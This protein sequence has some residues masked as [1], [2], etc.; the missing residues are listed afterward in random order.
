YPNP[1]ES[2]YD[3][4][5]TGHAGSSVSTALGLKSGDD[6]MGNLD[7]H[8][9]AV[10]GDG[11]FPSGIVFEAMNNASGLKKKLLVILND[12]KMSICPRVGGIA[13]YLD[14]LRM[15]R[16]YTN[17]KQQVVSILNKVPVVGDP[18]ERLLW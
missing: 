12:N 3:L 1:N 7:R 18:V 13:E 5:M 11:A 8:S 17:L 14:R 10:I 9:V 15:N 6:L 16:S 2:I 4:F